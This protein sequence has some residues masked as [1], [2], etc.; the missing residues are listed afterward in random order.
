M[1]W[2]GSEADRKEH[3]G[4]WCS[5]GCGNIS[6]GQW[7]RNTSDDLTGIPTILLAH[8]IHLL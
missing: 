5:W 7:K 4:A 3:S 8:S 1:F 2:G 6:L